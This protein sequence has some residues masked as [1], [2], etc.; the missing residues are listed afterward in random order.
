MT[1]RRR[2]RPPVMEARVVTLSFKVS[3]SERQRLAAV[4]RLNNV[5]LATFVRQAVQDAA[6]DCADG[7]YLRHFGPS[8]I[9]A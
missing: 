8:E 2:G 1:P 4:A 9:R 6:E 5:P 3:A 7:G